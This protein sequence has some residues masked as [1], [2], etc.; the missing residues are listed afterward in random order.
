MLLQ[1]RHTQSPRRAGLPELAA[2]LLAAVAPVLVAL[3]TP[4]LIPP[5]GLDYLDGAAQLLESGTMSGIVPYKAPGLTF[6]TAWMLWTDPSLKSLVWFQGIVILGTGVTVWSALRLLG[7]RWMAIVAGVLTAWHPSILTY[8]PYLLREAVAPYIAAWIA[9]QIIILFRDEGV[10]RSL[11]RTV[12]LSAVLGLG[13]G[14]GALYR[15]NFM[16]FVPLG[17]I[18][19]GVATFRASGPSRS[20]A[21][22]LGHATGAGAAVWLVAMLTLAPWLAYNHSRLGYAVLTVPKTQFNRCINAWANGLVDD[23]TTQ[24]RAV[25]DYA[26]VASLLVREGLVT[27]EAFERNSVDAVLEVMLRDPR[28]LERV[29]RAEA[30]AAVAANPRKA[31]HD[32]GWSLVSQLGL[33]DVSWHPNS[34]ANLWHS[35]PLRGVRAGM[36]SNYTFDVDGVM[37]SS[38]F[39]ARQERWRPLLA[40]TRVPPEA[41][42]SGAFA[43]A[44]DAWFKASEF[45]R[46][47]LAGV[48]LV[49]TVL[50]LAR[51][52]WG[53][54]AL[55]MI[56]LANV[57]GAAWMMTPLDRFAVPL[58]P[59]MIIVAA[60]AVVRASR[61]EGA[62]TNPPRPAA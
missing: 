24:P 50:A 16:A 44:F 6:F 28:T 51:R 22:R 42:P 26:F 29:C 19:A 31:A 21:A 17:I 40:A 49:G 30:D 15:E 34:R 4:V 2:L 58:L 35:E 8:Q 46:P 38:R 12:A 62:V 59:L 54:V 61:V 5:D 3:N 53:V 25:H 56:V 20:R 32:M 39:T 13:I 55:A 14:I 9:L 48:F 7:S 45:V 57:L 18:A 27:R 10:P 60:S 43:R 11:A 23:G 47:G 41:L 36:A 33:W 1:R 37:A 52:R